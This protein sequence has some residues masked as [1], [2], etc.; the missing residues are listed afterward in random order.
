MGWIAFI[1]KRLLYLPLDAPLAVKPFF[2]AVALRA[3][4]FSTLAFFRYR[5]AFF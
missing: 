2:F 1:G 4:G 5:N 3:L